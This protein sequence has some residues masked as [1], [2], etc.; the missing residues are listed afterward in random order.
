MSNQR[1]GPA[2]CQ[3]ENTD[4]SGQPRSPI[5]QTFAAS[6]AYR[7]EIHTLIPGGAHTYSRGDDQ[8][9]SLAPAAFVRGSGS[10]IWDIDGNEFVDCSMAL[11]SVSLGYAYEPVLDAVRVQLA[12]GAGFPRPASI[13]RDFA[14]EFIA[15][16]PGAERV[17]FAK[18]GSTVTTAAVK[19]A[20]AHTGRDMVAF[21]KNHPFYSFDDW[22]IGTTPCSSGI[23]EAIA[24]LSV[25]YDSSDPDSLRQLFRQFPD[26]IACVVTEPCDLVPLT[27]PVLQ[28]VAHI[29]REHGAVFIADEMLSGYRAGWPGACKSMGVVPDLTAWGKAIGNG[30]SISALTGRAEIMD[31]GGTQQR[32]APRVFLMSSTH[33]GET[34]S[35]AAARAVLRAY[36]TLDVLGHQRRIVASVAAGMRDAITTNDLS[37]SIQLNASDWRL[38][39]TCRNDDGTDSPARRTFLMQEMIRR[40][41]LFQSVFLPTYSHTSEDVV[42]IIQAFRESCA[43]Y[44]SALCAGG[45]LPLV[46]SPVRPVFRKYNGCLQV[47][48]HDP[49]PL[50]F[51]CRVRQ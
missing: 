12:H 5:V 37:K 42:A 46:G 10:R 9:P 8:F 14:R 43:A 50:D 25:C 34:H 6:E 40:G 21:T 47:C 30:F 4:L 16:C 13:E 19:L 18:N 33:G 36:K 15:E 23:P 31:L 17:R 41:I 1:M 27:R 3:T 11:G 22:F 48:E 49:C 45:A 26:K 7:A 2:A 44:R 32:S 51:S 35:I 39:V 29:S 20:R 24:N 28:D 38:Y